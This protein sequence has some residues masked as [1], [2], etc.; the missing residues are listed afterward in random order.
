MSWKYTAGTLL[1]SRY[2]QA[3]A[4]PTRPWWKL[5]RSATMADQNGDDR[6]VPPIPNQPGGFRP[7]LNWAQTLN[8][9]LVSPVQNSEYGVNS[10]AFTETSGTSRHGVPGLASWHWVE[11]LPWVVEGM[12]SPLPFWLVCRAL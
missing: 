9:V 4:R 6:L 7:P 8:G 3:S 11:R 10:S 5:S 2:S 12:F 1:N